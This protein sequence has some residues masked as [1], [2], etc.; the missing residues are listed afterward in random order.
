MAFLHAELVDEERLRSEFSRVHTCR[1]FAM[2][3]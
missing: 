3:L 1:R 2:E